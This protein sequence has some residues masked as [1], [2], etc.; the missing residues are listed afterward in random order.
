MLTVDAPPAI[1][2]PIQTF[3]ANDAGQALCVMGSFCPVAPAP[4][5]G[6]LTM[7]TEFPIAGGPNR[8]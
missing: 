5:P 4:D 8:S 7:R 2:A 6:S 1:D 3:S